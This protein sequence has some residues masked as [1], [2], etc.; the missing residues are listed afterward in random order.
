[1]KAVVC[2]IFLV[3][4][5]SV[6]YAQTTEQ[7]MLQ[8]IDKSHDSKQMAACTAKAYKQA[9]QRLNSLYKSTLATL[10]PTQKKAMTNSQAAW[11][12]FRDSYCTGFLANTLKGSDRQYVQQRCMTLLSEERSEHI[13]ELLVSP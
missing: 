8:C 10:T 12:K 13:S 6:V 2:L 5:L 11:I 7:E 3:A 4:S 9:E 1:M